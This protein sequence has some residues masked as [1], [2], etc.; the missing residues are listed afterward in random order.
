[1]SMSIFCVFSGFTIRSN[2]IPFYWKWIYWLDPYHYCLE[3]VVGSQFHQ[4]TSEITLLNG[5]TMTVEAF[6]KAAFPEWR[7]DHLPM[8]I[9]VMV[10]FLISTCLLRYLALHYLRHEKR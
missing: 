7:F 9:A 10:S 4:Y 5:Q 3:A 6:V 2:E 1:M 8:D